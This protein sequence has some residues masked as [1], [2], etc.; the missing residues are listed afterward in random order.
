MI[1]VTYQ[2]A[3]VLAILK[4]GE[5]YTAK[6]SIS[7]KGEY[8]ALIDMLDLK[9]QCP[10]FAV[11]KGRKQNTQGRVSGAVRI[12]LNVPNDKIKFTEYGVWADFLYAYQFAKSHDYS[13]L[14]PDCGEMTHRKYSG[15]IHNLKTPRPLGKYKYPQAIIEEIQPQWLVKYEQMP[16]TTKAINAVERLG[17]IFRK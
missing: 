8:A 17:N 3:T 6:P 5:T 4:K 11:V 10:I 12:T 13:R 2:S 9:C 1:L 7:Y 15:I 14:K 16:V